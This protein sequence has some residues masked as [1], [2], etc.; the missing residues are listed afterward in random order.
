MGL[1]GTSAKPSKSKISGDRPESSLW[2]GGEEGGRRGDG[3]PRV[4]VNGRFSII[5]LRTADES[6][7]ANPSDNGG[8]LGMGKMCDEISSGEKP[9]ASKPGYE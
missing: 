7:S 6:S 2:K 9:G 5:S 8:H 4:G 1:L 3:A